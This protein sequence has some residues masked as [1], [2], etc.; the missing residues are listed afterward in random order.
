M[1]LL[2]V[3]ASNCS[4]LSRCGT[5][6]AKNRGWICDGPASYC[7]YGEGAGTKCCGIIQQVGDGLVVAIDPKGC[8]FD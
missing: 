6:C 3:L 8:G 5:F 4:L 2:I 1:A 7:S